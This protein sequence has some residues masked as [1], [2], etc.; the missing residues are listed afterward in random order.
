MHPVIRIVFLVF[1][2]LFVT[3]GG[4]VAIALASLSFFGLYICNGPKLWLKLW[5]MLWRLR[6]FFLS[7]LFVYF[8]LTP[9]YALWV[10]AP[11]WL[12]TMEGLVGGIHRIIVLLLIVVA[13]QFFLLT[14][15]RS[16]LISALYWLASPFVAFGFPRERLVLR[17]FLVIETVENVR[18]LLAETGRSTQANTSKIKR[19]VMSVTILFQLIV[20]EVENSEL[21]CVQLD[22]L[23][24]PP[25]WQW[26]FP[27]LI[28]SLMLFL[29]D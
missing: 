26:C 17:I 13:V 18:Y 9:G 20:N 25:L 24:P 10:N 29:Y 6:W 11:A 7:I 15:E 5:P 21:L 16:Q 4:S 27:F 28:F 3:W 23:E 14:I 2:I 1:Y 8:S 22:L 19:I 12:P